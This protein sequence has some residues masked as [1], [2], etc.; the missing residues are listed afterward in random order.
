MHE[1]EP[2]LL[3]SAVLS[4]AV[5]DQHIHASGGTAI[6]DLTNYFDN[7]EID[8]TVVRFDTVFGEFDMELFDDDA[9]NTVLNFLGYVD[10]G[11]YDGTFIHRSVRIGQVEPGGGGG[12]TIDILQGGGYKYSAPSS[13]NR[14]ATNPPT[15]LNES[16]I[17]NTR[18]TIAMAR[19]ADPD[20]ATHEW[21]FNLDDANAVLDGDTETGYTVFGQVLGDGMDV[22]DE[23]A[24]VPIWNASSV[25]GAFGSLPLRDFTNDHFPNNSELVVINSVERAEELSYSVVSVSEPT[26]VAAI[27][28]ENGQLKIFTIG[29]SAPQTVTITVEAEDYDGNT[30]QAII[31]VEIG[32]AKESLNNDRLADLIWR[33][34]A[35]GQN[36]LWQMSGFNLTQVTPFDAVNSS[37][38]YIAATGDFNQDGHND[39]LWRNAF[40]GQNKVWLMDETSVQST[41]D[42]RTMSNQSWVVGGIADF[43]NDGEV[44]ILW[45]HTDKGRNVVWLMEGTVE[46]DAIRLKGQ[47]GAEWYIGGVGDFD[48]DGA[49]DILWRNDNNGQN[50]VWLLNAF[51]GSLKQSVALLT[52]ANTNWVAA[53]VADYNVD[54]QHDILFRNVNSGKQQVWVMNGTTRSNVR[55]DMKALRNLD[56]QLPGRTSQLAAEANAQAKIQRLKKRAA[57]L[58]AQAASATAL[59]FAAQSASA[60]VSL[61]SEVEPIID[62][63]LGDPGFVAEDDGQAA[64]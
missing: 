5:P 31:T 47:A 24:T 46:S 64:N 7:D 50:K 30:T 58:K 55:T 4:Q 44:D 54:N 15:V 41:V 12:S 33:N 61:L 35:S 16:S 43:D 1:L 37:T 34:F 53:A 62:L 52:F 49:A 8:G 14:I 3:L 39:L 11:D 18:G 48:R 17:S 38:W 13:Y 6:V 59:A 40:S 36:T 57:R 45:R 2:R 51:D 25:N 42:L 27:V 21:F 26:R 29:A 32:A 23:M 63:N 60:N 28:D 56:W 10:R 22:L 9:I 20:S 19:T